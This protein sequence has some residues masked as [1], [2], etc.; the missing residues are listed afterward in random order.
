MGHNETLI[1]QALRPAD[2]DRTVVSVDAMIRS[3]PRQD[4]ADAVRVPG[5]EVAGVIT[6]IGPAVDRPFA[7]GN[8]VMAIVVPQVSTAATGQTSSCRHARPRRSRPGSRTF[9]PP[10]SR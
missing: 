3:R 10:P 6:E 7:I 8:A 5:M 2:R 9:K 4:A 1:G